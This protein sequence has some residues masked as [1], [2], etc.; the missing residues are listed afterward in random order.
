MLTGEQVETVRNRFFK[1]T[2]ID[3]C[4]LEPSEIRDLLEL[5]PLALV[6]L[7]QYYDGEYVYAEEDED[8][9]LDPADMYGQ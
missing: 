4:V 1:A 7:Q 2:N 8:D 9:G 5:L 3:I 6:T